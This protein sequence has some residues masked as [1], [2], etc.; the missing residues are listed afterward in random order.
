[1]SILLNFDD[2]VRRPVPIH[3]HSSAA[4]SLGV[5]TCFVSSGGQSVVK[6][7]GVMACVTHGVTDDTL[8]DELFDEVQD[9]A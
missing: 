9:Y 1:M 7:F 6:T 5:L 2:G 3:L 4:Q 8:R